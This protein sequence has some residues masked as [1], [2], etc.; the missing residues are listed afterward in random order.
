METFYISFIVSKFLM[1]NTT[2]KFYLINILRYVYN[3][4]VKSYQNLLIARP[5]SQK[6]KKNNE[7]VL[8][9]FINGHAHG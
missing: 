2:Y 3:C 7:I 4:N 9:D 1:A 5:K 6:K 8:R